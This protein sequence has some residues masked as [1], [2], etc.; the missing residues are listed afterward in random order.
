R[1]R[2]KSVEQWAGPDRLDEELAAIGFYLSGHPLE[3]LTPALKRKRVTFVAE[4][5]A[6]AEAGHEAFQMAGVVR[7][8]QER[9]SARTGEKFAFV[10]FSDPTGEFECLFPPE[11]LRRCREVLEPGASVMVRVRAK[12]S[13][14]EV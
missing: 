3:D 1:P 6:L 4:A 11:Q 13:D 10:T 5:P 9:A 2:L 7:R 12:A 14:G 8:R